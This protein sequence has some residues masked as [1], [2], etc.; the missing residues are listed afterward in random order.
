MILLVGA[1]AFY[2]NSPCHNPLAFFHK[3]SNVELA[4]WTL[5]ETKHKNTSLN[6]SNKPSL[7]EKIG[8]NF[9][10]GKENCFTST[11]FFWGGELLIGFVGNNVWL[12]SCKANTS[13]GCWK[14]ATLPGKES[15]SRLI[16]THFTIAMEGFGHGGEEKLWICLRIW[17][18]PKNYPS[19]FCLLASFQIGVCGGV[20]WVLSLYVRICTLKLGDCANSTPKQSQTRYLV[21]AYFACKTGLPLKGWVNSPLSLRDRNTRWKPLKPF[22]GHIGPFPLE[23]TAGIASRKWHAP[24]DFARICWTLLLGLVTLLQYF[25]FSK[26][27][28]CVDIIY[29]YT[30]SMFWA[31]PMF[32]SHFKHD[33]FQTKMHESNSFLPILPTCSWSSPLNPPSVS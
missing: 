28:I 17:S 27:E 10:K 30:Y 15:H 26:L 12:V 23:T 33:F 11:H 21:W 2:V 18:I 29:I 3:T 16:F 1:V 31:F 9:P 5:W 6:P 7:P 25:L 20:K 14:A 8:R 19:V 4:P 24:V 32:F 13:R 22:D